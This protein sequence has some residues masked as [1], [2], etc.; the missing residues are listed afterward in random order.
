MNNLKIIKKDV[1]KYIENSE[2]GGHLTRSTGTYEPFTTTI[3]LVG[4]KKFY[5]ATA[6]KR[7]IKSI[8]NKNKIDKLKEQFKKTTQ[9]SNKIQRRLK[10]IERAIYALGGRRP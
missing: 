2:W 6:A 3:Y 8:K 9:H 1:T 4:R 5:R 10:K 7:Y